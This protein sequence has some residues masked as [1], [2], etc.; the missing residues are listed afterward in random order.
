MF[1][2]AAILLAGCAG[3]ATNWSRA[4]PPAGTKVVVVEFSDFNCPA[5]SAAA[6]TANKIKN[7]PNLYFEFRHFPLPLVGHDSSPAAANAFECARAQN[8]GEEMEAALFAN[9]GQ[10]GEKLFLAIPKKYNFGEN[11]DSAEFEKC[12][13]D[14]EF[15]DFVQKDVNFANSRGL[16]ATPTFFVNGTKAT[17]SNLLKTV[18]AAF[19]NAN[20]IE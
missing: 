2:L 12:V 13:V 7:L 15:D 11:F 20:S 5:C 3:D 18:A 10:L 6:A 17:R 4:T 14:G 19:E 16:N 1:G 9:S 8:F